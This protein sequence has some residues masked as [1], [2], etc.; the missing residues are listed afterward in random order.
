[1]KD[2]DL[3]ALE[4][5]SLERACRLLGCELNDILHWAELSAIPLMVKF[6]HKVSCDARIIFSDKID[7]Y[8]SLRDIDP[9]DG[10]FKASQLSSFSLTAEDNA[11]YEFEGVINPIHNMIEYELECNLNGF[12]E[13]I[14][15][16]LNEERVDFTAVKPFRNKYEW[17][18]IARYWGG[19]EFTISDLY[20]SRESIEVISGVK[21]RALLSI[22]N[23]EDDNKPR[24]ISEDISPKTRNYRAVFIKSLLYVC[25]GED[26]ADN[27]R[28]FFDNARSKIKIDFEKEGI[29][30]PSGKAIEAWLKD[31]D[32][33]KK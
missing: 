13:L 26:A 25:Y 7:L 28:K 14:N 9:G 24:M 10:N 18:S 11:D 1:M 30:L 27:P 12:W 17:I 19:T 22:A 3:P 16:T 2:F 6:T 5:C 21:Q 33:G 23:F 20:I 32:I 8:E 31:V 15:F 4:Y 29:A